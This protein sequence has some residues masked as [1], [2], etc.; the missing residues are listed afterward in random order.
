VALRGAD[1]RRAQAPV[2]TEARPRGASSTDRAR[3]D[4][5]AAGRARIARRAGPA[6]RDAGPRPRAERRG[7]PRG[8]RRSSRRPAEGPPRFGRRDPRPARPARLGRGRAQRP[9]SAQPRMGSNRFPR[10]PRRRA[11]ARCRRRHSPRH[12]TPPRR[13]RPLGWRGPAWK[14]GTFVATEAPIVPPQGLVDVGNPAPILRRL[15][16]PSRDAHA[17]LPGSSELPTCAG[18]GL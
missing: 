9:S 6:A 1:P 17:A 7:F 14:E 16:G 4:R 15:H 11:A 8:P 18:T 5:S 13:D 10:R 3:V 2:D 12:R